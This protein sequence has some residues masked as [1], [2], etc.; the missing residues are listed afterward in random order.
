MRESRYIEYKEVVSK[1]FL[2]VVSAF[3]NYNDGKIIFGIR[4]DG[5]VQGLPDP[6]K[7][8][9]DIENAINDSLSPVPDYEI[10][11]NTN[12]NG[13]SGITVGKKYL[14]PQSL[15]CFRGF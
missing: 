3:A 13:S 12:N 9:I 6:Y 4:D 5:S 1:T 14:K 7:A 15:C 8:S 2:K 10:T 11:V